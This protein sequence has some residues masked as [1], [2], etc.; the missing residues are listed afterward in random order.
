MESR[1]TETTTSER[2]K[3]ENIRKKYDKL[4]NDETLFDYMC[5]LQTFYVKSS[6]DWINKYMLDGFGVQ[7]GKTLNVSFNDVQGK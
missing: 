4:R 3:K 7:K 2:K 5:S 1:S 6:V